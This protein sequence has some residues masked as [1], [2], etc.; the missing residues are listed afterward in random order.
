MRN[1][2][3]RPKRYYFYKDIIDALMKRFKHRTFFQVILSFDINPLSAI[4]LSNIGI[5][6]IIWF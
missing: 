3:K 2:I 5:K 6:L 1:Q 4:N